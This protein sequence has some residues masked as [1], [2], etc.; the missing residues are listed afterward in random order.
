MLYPTDFAKNS[1]AGQTISMVIL[2]LETSAVTKF[3]TDV[4]SIYDSMAIAKISALFQIILKVIICIFTAILYFLCKFDLAIFYCGQVVFTFFIALMLFRIILKYQRKRYPVV[5]SE[6]FKIYFKEYLI[7][8]RPLIISSIVSQIIIILM[9]WCLMRFS[10]ATEQAMFGA[11]WQLNSLLTF[12][13]APYA[14]LSK[15]E[16]SIISNN[17]NELKVFY[18]SSLRRMFWLTA[19]FACFFGFCCV[20]FFFFFF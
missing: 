15:R 16:Y 13:F 20:L 3:L 1:F 5:K 9:N 7:F 17:N 6:S 18:E 14:E 10:G 8:C 19:Y 11:A 2:G 12:I 4:I